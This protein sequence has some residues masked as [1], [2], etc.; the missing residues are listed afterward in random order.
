MSI[1]YPNNQVSTAIQIILNDRFLFYLWYPGFEGC[2]E[3]LALNGEAMP[4]DGSNEMF[5]AVPSEN[6]GEGCTGGNPCIPAPCAIDEIC[7]VDGDGYQCQPA[8]ACLSDPC[9]NQGTCVPVVFDFVCRCADGFE[10]LYCHE[11]SGGDNNKIIIIVCVFVLVLLIV[12]IL[13]LLLL[14]HYRLK[15]KMEK[16]QRDPGN[17]DSRSISID[18][19]D[20][21]GFNGDTFDDATMIGNVGHDSKM[22]VMVSPPSV[23]STLQKHP[24]IIDPN[25]L[26]DATQPDSSSGGEHDDGI[27][28]PV[29]PDA[30]HYDIENASSIAPSDIDVAYHYRYYHDHER[31]LH[32]QRRSPN[33]LLMHLQQQQHHMTTSAR[34]SPLSHQSSGQHLNNLSHRNTPNHLTHRGS[35]NIVLAH[36]TPLDRHS[37]GITP[38]QYPMVDLGSRETLRSAMPLRGSR[39]NTPSQR[40]N[41]PN[42]RS[43]SNT[44][45]HR[46][47]SN[48]PSHRSLVSPVHSMQ[49]APSVHSVQS[50]LR[51]VGHHSDKSSVQ[52]HRSRTKSPI[53]TGLTLAAQQALANQQQQKRMSPAVMYDTK[54]PLGLTVEEVAKLNTSRPELMVGSHTSTIDNLS[55]GSED[56]CLSPHTLTHTNSRP[57]PHLLEAPSSDDDTNDSFTCSEVDSD[58]DR[59]PR[60]DSD[61]DPGSIILSRLAEVENENEYSLD[62]CE[63]GIHSQPGSLIMSDEENLKRPHKRT[64]NGSLKWEDFLNWGPRFDSFEGV[65]KDIA[66]LQD[67]M[68]VSP[69]TILAPSPSTTITLEQTEEEFV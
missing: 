16:K 18:A 28:S 26:A 42:H 52:S 29:E 69:Q 40:S 54:V 19:V 43:R 38:N 66:Q 27:I 23:G 68:A 22:H 49:S 20:N 36:S 15:A 64:L 3:N 48:T 24:D 35:P 37:P 51:S 21:P 4:L 61:F 60:M 63:G 13:C 50:E 32:Q 17:Y 53:H 10:G 59:M 1:V 39:A 67:V 8:G 14:R 2:I 5:E 33:P 57:S 44:P 9:K 65:F 58:L 34:A 25:D 56:R 7:H 12:V 46:S 45:N 6:T 62:P 41:T 11:V 47:R 55:S 30:E 31:K